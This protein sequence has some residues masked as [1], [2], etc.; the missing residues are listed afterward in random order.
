M[1]KSIAILLFLVS[2]FQFQSENRIVACTILPPGTVDDEVPVDPAPPGVPPIV[3]VGTVSCWMEVRVNCS[4]FVGSGPFDQ[5][6][7]I[8]CTDTAVPNGNGGITYIWTCQDLSQQFGV[9]VDDTIPRLTATPPGMSGLDS[10]NSNIDHF[11]GW[12]QTCYCPAGNAGLGGA[13]PRCLFY[14]P[15]LPGALIPSQKPAGEPCTDP[16]VSGGN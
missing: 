3:P 1:K 10:F 5:C 8:D 4:N 14:S 12:Y 6:G 16:A 13:V 11:C 15:K 2:A 9:D 7:G